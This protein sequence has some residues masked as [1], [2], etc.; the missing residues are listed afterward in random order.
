MEILSYLTIP[1]QEPILIL[2]VALG[3]F[4]GVYIGAIPGLSATMAVS[5]LVSFTFGWETHSALALMI[6]I[7][8]GAVYGG[9]R[10]AIL[11]NIPGAPAA[12]A[13]ALDGYPLAKKGYAGVAMGIAT[14]Q[15]IIGTLIGILVLALFTP[16]ISKFALNFSSIDYLLLGVM[17]MMMAGSL[18]SKSIFRGL[19]AAALGVLLGTVGMDTMTATPRFT[20][21]ILYLHTGVDYVIAMIGLFGVSEALIQITHKDAKAVRQ[22]IGRIVPSLATCRKHLPL[23]LQSSLIGVLVGALPGAGGDVAALLSYDTAKRSVKNPDVPF[24]EGSV[25]GLV[26]P[27]TANNAAIGGAFIPMLTLGIPGDSVTAVML[28]ALMVHGLK[29]GPNLMNTS[30]DLFCL[31]VACLVLAAVFLVIFGLTGVRLF[32]KIVEIPKGILLPLILILSAVGSYAI[33]SSLTDVFWMFGF[34]ILGYFMKRYDYPV[35]PCVLGLIL[36]SLLEENFRRG[37]MLNGSIG[38]MFLSIFHSPISVVLFVLILVMFT[39]Q[40]KTY[41]SWRDKRQGMKK[42]Q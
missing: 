22:K 2:F 21:N 14:T 12:V 20:F 3:C 32:T 35:A 9:S 24:G 28:A 30:P 17:G 15:S 10:S 34:G 13:T 8:V 25:E 42:T 11:L 19:L 18:G 38:G 40:T 29:P 4:A 23:T 41:K 26:A 6:G 36:S 33:N 39:T 31:I 7:F 27:E 5:L 1:I 37:V 16:V